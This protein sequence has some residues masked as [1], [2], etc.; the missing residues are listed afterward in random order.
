M[1][2]LPIEQYK[3]PVDGDRGA[4]PGGGD[5][6]F[7]IVQ[8]L[9]VPGGDAVGRRRWGRPWRERFFARRHFILKSGGWV[10]VAEE[11]VNDS[12]P[13]K[14]RCCRDANNRS[15]FIIESSKACFS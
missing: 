15:S 14:A 4:H 13:L 2:D 11:F 3:F 1:A 8:Q 7:Q 12:S 5:A 6:L 10:M 9:F